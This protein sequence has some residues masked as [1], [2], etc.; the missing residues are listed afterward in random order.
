MLRL[1]TI[2]VIAVIGIVLVLGNLV[3]CSSANP[4]TESLAAASQPDVADQPLIEEALFPGFPA[5]FEFP[6]FYRKKL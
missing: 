6:D 1:V 4:A 3:S 2:I 5:D